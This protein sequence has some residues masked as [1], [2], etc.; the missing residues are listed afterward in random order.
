MVRVEL[1][2][3]RIGT[4][5]AQE[6][7]VRARQGHAGS[8]GSP[9]YVFLGGRSRSGGNSRAILLHQLDELF[10]VV[11]QPVHLFWRILGLLHGVGVV[12]DHAGFLYELFRQPF[13]FVFAIA[14][15][16]AREGGRHGIVA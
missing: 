1:E 3:A 14:G 12:H 15:Q 8:G 7:D 9:G 6:P 10:H 16:N 11:S 5:G 13:D 2:V 4:H